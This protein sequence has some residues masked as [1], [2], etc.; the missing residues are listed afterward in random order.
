MME[1]FRIG[2]FADGPWGHLT[3]D[4]LLQ[5]VSLEIAF[6]VP[7][8]DTKDSYLKSKAN[9]YGI[10]YLVPVKV[11]SEEFY[12]RAEAYHCDLFVSMSY[13]QIF[14]E[15][16]YNLPKYKTINC[17]A[18]KLPFYRGRN[19]LN[20]ALIN[21]EKEFGITVHYV[22]DGIDTGDIILQRTFPI[23][24]EDDYDTLL[25]VAY[26]ECPK[27]L[28]QAIKEIQEGTSLRI[29]Q[30]IISLY[31]AYCGMR[32]VGDELIDWGQTS[33]EIFNFVRSICKPGPMAA[34]FCT[35]ARVLVNKVEYNAGYPVYKG[36]PGQIIGM[37]SG[38]P[39]V[40]TKDSYVK[41]LQY[42]SECKLRVGDRLA[43]K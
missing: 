20:W 35:R 37:D 34:T 19:I 33:R 5:D 1:K 26:A 31:G 43:S 12:Q 40:K 13:N 32:Q 8:N 3:L 29:P 42:E 11:N 14:R 38:C 17:H 27:I 25:K 9:D 10:D 22:D 18:G 30:D 23:T 7:R 41:I 39:I 2:Y 15:R 4:K 24:D 21:D 6:I 36:I 16:I 28:Y